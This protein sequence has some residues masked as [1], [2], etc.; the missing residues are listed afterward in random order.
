MSDKVSVIVPVYNVEPYLRRC[1]DSILAQRHQNFEIL[2]IDDGSADASGAICDQYAA[3][4]SRIIVIH[5]EN[6]G[7]S[8]ARN[9][10]LDRCSGEYVSFIDPD[11]WIEKDMFHVMLQAFG[12]LN[13]DFAVCNEAHVIAEAEGIEIKQIN[14]WPELSGTTTVKHSAL[15]EKI[16]AR[17]AIMCNKIVKRAIIGEHRW[18]PSLS[19]GEDFVFFLEI[20]EGCHSAVIVPNCYYNYVIKRPGNVVSSGINQ[21]SLELLDNTGMIYAELSKR[22]FSGVGISRLSIS[23]NEVI[24]KIPERGVLDP[25]YGKYISACKKL[26]RLPSS[27]DVSIFLKSDTTSLKG[28]CA[29][30]LMRADF[31]LWF[32][33]K[34]LMRKAKSSK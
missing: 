33:V 13:V 11:D 14:H 21:K 19:Y 15:Y 9:A 2:L 25:A 5:Q 8:S 3:Q 4:D 30:L 17:T 28:K 12:E 29:Y 6:K 22:G 16:F 7:V 10:G 1:V 31:A 27:H 32:K 24:G 18:N 34:R 23:V 20:L 26:A